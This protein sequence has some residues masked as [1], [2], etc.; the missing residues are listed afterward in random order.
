[1]KKF[2]LKK[3]YLFFTSV[4]IFIL[5]MPFVF[6]KAKPV[7]GYFFDKPV[8]QPGDLNDS[9]SVKT[10]SIGNLSFSLYDS[11]K[12]NSLGLGRQVFDYAMK[13][14]NFMKEM[15]TLGNEQIISI[16]DLANHLP[17]KDYSS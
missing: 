12:L 13:G 4:C 15:G 1:M 9:T 2:G 5:H 3:I 11:L 7:V 17:R 6:A 10:D 8:R 16:V 14:F